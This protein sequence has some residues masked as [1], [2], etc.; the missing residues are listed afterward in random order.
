MPSSSQQFR[1]LID[2]AKV[3]N[4]QG[5]LPRARELYDSAIDLD[6]DSTEV[7]QKENLPYLASAYAFYQKI[8]IIPEGS[9]NT[10]AALALISVVTTS[11]PN[12]AG[13]AKKKIDALNERLGLIG[14][15]FLT[16]G[17]VGTAI[18]GPIGTIVGALAGSA[19]GFFVNR[20]E[21]KQ[22]TQASIGE[23]EQNAK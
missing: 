16:G 22:S 10:I 11:I 9:K 12:M 21:S 23:D 18:A 2:K 17:A 19:V 7:V 4:E 20:Y 15:G 14:S 3:A 5:D 1:S 6:L 13:A 8:G